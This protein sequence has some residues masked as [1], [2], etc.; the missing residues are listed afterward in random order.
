[1]LAAK[2]GNLEILKFIVNH[3]GFLGEQD[4]HSKV[5]INQVVAHENKHYHGTAFCFSSAKEH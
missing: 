1:M 3:A 2:N 5:D 4:E